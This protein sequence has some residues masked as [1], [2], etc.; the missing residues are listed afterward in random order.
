MT[1]PSGTVSFLFTDIE[2]STKLLRELGSAYAQLLSEHVHIL[3]AEVAKTGGHELELEGDALFAAFERARDAVACAAA[4]QVALASHHWP[5]NVEVRV[6]MGID[7]GEP[8]VSDG[9]YTGLAVHRAARIC[10]AAH[11]GQVLVSEAAHAMVAEEQLGEI[12]FLA[13]GMHRLKDFDRPQRLYQVSAPGLATVFPPPRTLAEPGAPAPAL[14]AD[15]RRLRIVVADDSMLVREGTAR[16]LQDAGFEVVGRAATAED[17]LADVDRQLPDLAVTDIKMPPGFKDEGLRAAERIRETHPDIG[18]LVLSQ[19]VEARYAARLLELYPSR[20][21]YL[22]K[23][24]LSEMAVLTDAIRR[25]DDGECVVDPT[26]VQR[27]MKRASGA[28]TLRD[29]T[30]A[31]RVLLALTA[32]GHSDDAIASRVGMSAGEVAARLDELFEELGVASTAAEVRRAAP[33]LELLRSNGPSSRA[34]D[35]A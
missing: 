18:V 17:L 35:S 6:R 11:G 34:A 21:G 28:G 30:D 5:G 32:E 1:L 15:E 2:G 20:V 8:R 22:L 4:A 9:R 26:I 7:T 33:L 25:I 24:R 19:Y 3:R 12:E 14:R 16:L 29:V 23:D 27:L 13:L 31:D 10:A